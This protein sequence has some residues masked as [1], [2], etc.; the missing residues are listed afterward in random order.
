MLSDNTIQYVLGG[1][2]SGRW[3]LRTPTDLPV[4]GPQPCWAGV[5]G[6]TSGPLS[7]LL[8]VPVETSNKRVN[9]LRPPFV[10]E[11][12]WASLNAKVGYEC[13]YLCVCASAHICV[14]VSIVCAHTCTGTCEHMCILLCTCNTCMSAYV[15]ICM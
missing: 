8:W 1:C 10:S 13:L 14:N 2:L 6:P 7:S 15:Y 11:A 3:Q 9:C 5:R 4:P 12:L